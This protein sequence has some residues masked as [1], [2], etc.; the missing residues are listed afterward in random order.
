MPADWDVIS[1]PRRAAL[2]LFYNR[3]PNPPDR[4]GLDLRKTL[5]YNFTGLIMG[6]NVDGRR[7]IFK[8]RS[9]IRSKLHIHFRE[10]TR[11]I[12]DKTEYRGWKFFEIRENK[13]VLE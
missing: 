8:N 6:V 10:S 2:G 13:D 4:Q 3:Q 7:M 12:K 9:E 11:A 5:D 1:G